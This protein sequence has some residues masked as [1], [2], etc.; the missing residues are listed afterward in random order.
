VARGEVKNVP[1]ESSEICADNHTTC[2][3]ENIDAVKEVFD[4]ETCLAML[5]NY[6]EVFSMYLNMLT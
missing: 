1:Q 2:V 6:Y 5:T 4:E 3:N